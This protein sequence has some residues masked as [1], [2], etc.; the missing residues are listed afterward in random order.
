MRKYQ[1]SAAVVAAMRNRA[2][3]A[4]FREV[5]VPLHLELPRYEEMRAPA[6]AEFDA[7][8][9]R[10]EAGGITIGDADDDFY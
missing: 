4:R 8:D 1:V 6:V 2:M 9:G 5:G 7:E 3:A 10:I